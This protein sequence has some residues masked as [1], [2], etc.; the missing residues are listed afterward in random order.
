M[1]LMDLMDF[2]I[3]EE[4]KSKFMFPHC[5]TCPIMDALLS[6]SSLHISGDWGG[7]PPLCSNGPIRDSQPPLRVQFANQWVGRPPTPIVV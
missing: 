2:L 3:L 5:A 7:V 4:D 1:D 6:Q